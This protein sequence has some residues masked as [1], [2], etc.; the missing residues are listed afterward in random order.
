M[1][2]VDQ[3]ADSA[4]VRLSFDELTA[5]TNA[6]NEALEHLDE[7]EFDTRMGAGRV[8]VEELLKAMSQIRIA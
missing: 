7:W 1:E 3:Q 5:L 2:V 6:L 8:E 4:L